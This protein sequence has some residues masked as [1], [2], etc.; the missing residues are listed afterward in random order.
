M[1]FEVIDGLDV[2]LD[3]P[4]WRLHMAHL[5][6]E[7]GSHEQ[8]LE[9][10][11]RGTVARVNQRYGDHGLDGQANVCALRDALGD[12]LAS[13]EQLVAALLA[14]G[15]FPGGDTAEVFRDLLAARTLLPWSLMDARRVRFPMKF[16]L[17]EQGE[18]GTL[19]GREV[20]LE[21]L[22]LLTDGDGVVG[23][24]CCDCCDERTHAGASEVILVCYTPLA[25]SR[26]FDARTELARMVWTTWA[27][28]F[29]SEKAFR[30]NG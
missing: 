12:T 29:V 17:G 26:Q 20:E 19:A 6:L 18:T 7:Q 23:S 2:F 13:S 9:V 22:P 5:A 14:G 10:M 8:V 3:A 30:P 28:R 24:P 1:D 25:V 21:G 16:R 15:S 4:G 11:I 27:F